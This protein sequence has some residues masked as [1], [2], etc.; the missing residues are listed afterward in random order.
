M[1]GGSEGNINPFE[2]IRT[3]ID[4]PKFSHIF[5][6]DNTK[7]DHF[8]YAKNNLLI[9]LLCFTVY[10]IYI[11]FMDYLDSILLAVLSGKYALM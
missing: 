11:L 9:I 7:D 2:I 5:E 6:D 3:V 4:E 1:S 8:T 10:S